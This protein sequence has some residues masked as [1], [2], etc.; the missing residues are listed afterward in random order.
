M[1]R[2]T[3]LWRAMLLQVR[4]RQRTAGIERMEWEGSDP[5]KCEIWV[6]DS[7]VKRLSANGRRQAKAREAKQADTEGMV[8]FGVIK[9]L[10]GGAWKEGSNSKDQASRKVQ[11]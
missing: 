11:S 7:R 3:R 4:E 10:R 6:N 5:G 9:F 1:R 2:G 8:N